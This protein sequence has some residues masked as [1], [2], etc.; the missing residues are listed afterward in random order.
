MNSSRFYH[1]YYA[2]RRARMTRRRGLSLLSS[3][4][5]SKLLKSLVGL[6]LLKIDVKEREAIKSRDFYSMG[7]REIM[8]RGVFNVSYM[9][10]GVIHRLST[11]YT[12]FKLFKYT[13]T[14]SG[15]VRYRINVRAELS[16]FYYKD[17]LLGTTTEVTPLHSTFMRCT[18][19][20]ENKART[21]SVNC[22]FLKCRYS[23][24]ITTPD[25][26]LIGDIEYIEWFILDR[27]D[28]EIPK[29]EELKE[30]LT[31]IKE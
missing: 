30:Q 12:I 24:V 8:N 23:L 7:D 10:E 2:R 22:N 1:K 25:K 21:E 26:D 27:L 5:T 14:V 15:A 16:K 11:N 29:Y 6:N 9:V 31:G 20:T 3:K 19:Y 28:R 4:L 13:K 17:A 18:L